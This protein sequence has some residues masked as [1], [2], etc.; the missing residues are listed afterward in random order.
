MTETG[1]HVA[2]VIVCMAFKE[3]RLHDIGRNQ[4]LS[5]VKKF[6]PR[7]CKQVQLFSLGSL[8]RNIQHRGSLTTVL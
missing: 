3:Y 6:Q 5:A 7:L 2:L 1:S 4:L 8:W